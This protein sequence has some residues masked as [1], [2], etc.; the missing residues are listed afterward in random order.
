[1]SY[2][3]KLKEI[4]DSYIFSLGKCH[5]DLSEL[6]REISEVEYQ[7][8]RIEGVYVEVAKSILNWQ[9]LGRE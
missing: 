9:S 1:M 3:E 6:L 5:F 4:H 8:L 7:K 2:P